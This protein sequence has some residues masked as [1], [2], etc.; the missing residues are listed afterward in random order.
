[1]ARGRAHP[2]TA[3]GPGEPAG[4]RGAGILPEDMWCSMADP[5]PPPGGANAMTDAARPAVG[6]IMG[7]ASDWET[8]RHAVDVLKELDIPHEVRVV[9]AHRTPDDMFEYA[10]TAVERGLKV[11]IAGA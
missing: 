2:S 10:G 7:S 5:V 1:M 3:G 8:M 6:V 4:G 11:I 9:S